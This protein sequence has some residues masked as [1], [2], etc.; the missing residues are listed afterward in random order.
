[1][2]EIVLNLISSHCTEP[3]AERS[4]INLLGRTK[5]AFCSSVNRVPASLGWIA[6]PADD[7]YFFYEFG[8]EHFDHLDRKIPLHWHK[9]DGIDRIAQIGPVVPNFNQWQGQ[10][11]ANFGSSRPSDNQRDSKPS[12]TKRQRLQQCRLTMSVKVFHSNRNAGRPSLCRKHRHC[13][14]G[15]CSIEQSAPGSSRSKVGRAHTR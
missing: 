1:M 4:M 15:Q 5:I 13:S 11:T 9:L 10:S 7:N 3:P 2:N 12:L 6:V 8:Y 14:N